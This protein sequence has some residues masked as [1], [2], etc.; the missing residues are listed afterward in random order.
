M[1]YFLTEL[2]IINKMETHDKLRMYANIVQELAKA[3]TCARV[4]VGAILIKDGRIIS[5]AW[6][7]VAAG[8]EHCKQVFAGVDLTL[9][10]N[11]EKHKK[12]SSSRELHAEQNLIGLAA[13][14]GISTNNTTL[15]VTTSP[16]SQCAKLIITAGISSVYYI[17]VYDRDPYGLVLLQDTNIITHQIKLS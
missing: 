17:D 6:N 1:I 3:S 9:E 12:F 5:T 13:K 4:Q 8:Q 16:C 15:I 7:G 14:N 2:R 11:K 10:E